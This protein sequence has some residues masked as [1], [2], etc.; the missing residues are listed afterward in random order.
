MANL[1]TIIK[2]PR[3]EAELLQI[4]P[5]IQ[6]ADA[7]IEGVEWLLC[8]EP[9]IG[10]RLGHS[11]VYFVPG[12]TIDLNVYYTFNDDEVFFLSICRMEPPAP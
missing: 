2:N 6:R 4:E 3:F 8:R 1:R 10:T 12:W 5:N 11:H 9:Q 7:F